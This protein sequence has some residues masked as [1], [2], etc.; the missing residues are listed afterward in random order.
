MQA[1]GEPR[2][3]GSAGERGGEGGGDDSCLGDAEGERERRRD[4]VG[5]LVENMELDL[6]PKSLNL[7]LH[8]PCENTKGAPKLFT[9]KTVYT[10]HIR[11]PTDMVLTHEA[12]T[13]RC[14]GFFFL[15]GHAL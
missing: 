12:Q 14:L 6:A 7:G 4:E 9:A 5:C 11:P 1:G 3:G 15:V 2:V 10:D 8:L 13:G